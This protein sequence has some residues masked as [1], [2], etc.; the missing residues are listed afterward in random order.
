M[1]SSATNSVALGQGS[2]ATEANTVSVGTSSYQRRI[3]NVADGVADS[4]AATVG[5]LNSAVTD[6]TALE[7]RVT[8]AEGTIATHTAEIAANTAAIGAEATDRAAADASLQSNIDNEATARSAAD[9]TLQA[10]ID[11]NSSEIN[12]LQEAGRGMSWTPGSA[13]IGAS[14]TGSGSTSL[15]DGASA[16]D[17]DTALGYMATVTADGSVAVGADTL[18]EAGA[19][20]SS[21][22]GQGARVATGASGS[23]ALGQNSVAS[24]ANTV[25]VGSAGNERRLTNI[26]DGINDTD[27]ANMGQLRQAAAAMQADVSN[28]QNRVGK[29]ERRLDDVGAL[30]SA[31]S[32]LVPNARSAGNTQIALGAGYYEGSTAMA[33]GLFHYVSKNVLLNA[34]VSTAFNSHS[35]AGRAGV[36]FGW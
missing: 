30:S 21:A 29:V 34:G 5:Q 10:N 24:E 18:V 25:S 16:R 26:A 12:N 19:D 1:S 23:V 22:L 32:A 8:T 20:G 6:V 2:Q 9:A 35:T 33:A 31:F 14:A 28:L 13:V 15:G 36:T 7:G 27:A 17:R 11:T 4:D 3:V